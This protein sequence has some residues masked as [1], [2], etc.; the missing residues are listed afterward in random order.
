MIVFFC[1]LDMIVGCVVIDLEDL[2]V[3]VVIRFMG[4]SDNY[5]VI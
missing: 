1:R 4:G 2:N 5:G 3:M